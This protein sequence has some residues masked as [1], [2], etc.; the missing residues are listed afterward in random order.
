MGFG[1]IRIS[2]QRLLIARARGGEFALFSE[3]VG[4]VKVDG[5]ARRPAL[6]LRDA[7]KV[8]ESLI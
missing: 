2:P 8:I 3:N 6:Y 7:V 1:V 4:G 5:M